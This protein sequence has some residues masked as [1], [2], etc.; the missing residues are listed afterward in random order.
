MVEDDYEF[1]KP[2]EEEKVLHPTGLRPDPSQGEYGLNKHLDLGSLLI[3]DTQSYEG[4]SMQEFSKR[5][6]KSLCQ[7]YKALFEVKKK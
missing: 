6:A 1:E 7:L 5:T 4:I 3:E 2:E